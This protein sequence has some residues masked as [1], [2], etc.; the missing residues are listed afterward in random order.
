MQKQDVLKK[1]KSYIPNFEKTVNPKMIHGTTPVKSFFS[2]RKDQKNKL[3]SGFT[4]TYAIILS[5]IA[6]LLIYYVWAL[7]ANATQ[8]YNIQQ[9][10]RTQNE[11]RVELEKLNAKIAELWSSDAVNNQEI[12][13]DME[14]IN[15]PNYLV[16][17]NG[18]Q[19]VYNY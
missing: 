8:W 7:N 12:L 11:L 3:Q 13:K 9:L 1:Y 16:I 6:F 15:D 19:Y 4:Q 10:K 5:I 2:E 18:V 14:A 17:R